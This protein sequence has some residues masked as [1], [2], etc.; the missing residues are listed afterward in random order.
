MKIGIGTYSLFWEFESRNPSPLDIPGMI[1]R[2][3]IGRASC[4]ER[5]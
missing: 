5:V 2:A 4:R 1:D 3:E